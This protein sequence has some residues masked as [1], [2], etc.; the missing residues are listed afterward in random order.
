MAKLFTKKN[1]AEIYNRL[2]SVLEELIHLHENGNSVRQQ[3]A[4]TASLHFIALGLQTAL[5]AI[6]Q[7]MYMSS[8][9]HKSQILTRVIA[10]GEVLKGS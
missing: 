8:A 10:Q 1:N 4:S 7:E 5:T 6:S 3:K 9:N 2:F